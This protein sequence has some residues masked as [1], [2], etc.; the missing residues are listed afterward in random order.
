[1]RLRRLDLTRYGKFT[2]FA[3]DFGDRTGDGPD[4]HIVYG[5]NEAGKSTAFA[6]YL[7][8]LFGIEPQSRYDFLHGYDTMEIGATLEI[9][10]RHHALRRFKQRTASLRDAT[11][12]PVNEALLGGALSGLSREAYR[13]MFSLDDQTLEDGG[14]A[15]LESK[16][17]LGELLFAASAGLVSLSKTLAHIETQADA[18]FRKR[19]SSTEIAALKRRLSDLKDERERIDTQANAHAKL[20]AMLKQADDA[21]A[22][23]TQELAEFKVRKGGLEGLLRATPHAAEHARLGGD[24]DELGDLPRPPGHWQNRLPELMVADATL[25]E[26]L[27]SADDRVRKLQAEV[28]N[29]IVDDRLLRLGDRIQALL[30]LM[31]RFQGAEDDLPK[32]RNDLSTRESQLAHIARSLTGK[33]DDD[34]DALVVEASTLGTLRALLERWSGVETKHTTAAQERDGATIALEQAVEDRDALTRTH[35][36]LEAGLR[37]TLQAS[38]SRVREDGLLARHPRSAGA[39]ADKKREALDALRLLAPWPGSSDELADLIVP[40]VRQLQDWRDLFTRLL[41]RRDGY[42]DE[43]RSLAA[44]QALMETRIATAEVGVSA[45]TDDRADAAR[46]TREETWSSHL[47]RLDLDSASIFE[48]A[49]R[50]LDSLS[51]VRIEANDRL[52][53]I[54]SLRAE[55]SNIGVKSA[56]VGDALAETECELAAL[57]K[58]IGAA[59]PAGV[60]GGDDVLPSSM[61]STI[62]DWASKRATALKTL[63]DE[64]A[65]VEELAEIEAAIES[66]GVR[67]GKALAK[68]GIAVEGLYFGALLSAS[69]SLVS[70]EAAR[71]E[72]QAAAD[73]LVTEA[74]RRLK[75]RQKAEAEAADARET[76]RIAW[77]RALAGSWL[78]QFSEDLDAIRATLTALETLPALLSARDDI[79]HRV[80]AMED[81]RRIFRDAV[82]ALCRDAGE[83]EKLA[84]PPEEAAKILLSRHAAAVQAH[85]LRKEKAIEL[86]DSERRREHIFEEVRLHEVERHEMLALLS[87]SDLTEA[88]KRL[89]L[90]VRREQIEEKHGELSTQI[91]RDTGSVSLELALALLAE[92]APPERAQ[93]HAECMQRI[94][95]LEGRRQ[96]LFAER[97][98]AVDKVSAIGGDDAAARIEGDRRTVILEIED[99]AV[100]YLHLKTGNLLAERALQAYREQHRGSM[101]RRASEAFRNITRG[102][103]TGLTTIPEKERETLIALPKAGGSKNANSLSKGTRFQLYLALRVAGYEEFLLGQQPVPFISDDILETFDEP[104]SEVVLSVFEQMSRRGQVICFTH[105]RHICDLARKVVPTVQV[106]E[107]PVE[108]IIEKQVG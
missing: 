24:L 102:S 30:P 104:R 105:H 36:P 98:A 83:V 27:K 47:A 92:Q 90:C 56:M 38:V 86:S 82:E 1:M 13:V 32:R 60:N 35:P 96:T 11:G 71:F 108:Q 87:V 9:H 54:R 41:L 74:E 67:L 42:R 79:R 40:S 2:D 46:L 26:K 49:M 39:A 15:I 16:G 61:I 62:E 89:R 75:T 93:A 6:A 78:V 58:T 95:D 59:L 53:E 22:Q 57:A 66:E 68:A 88:E 3:L 77:A 18:I 19:A 31:S 103:Y 80:S 48:Q 14:K 44:Q 70:N 99:K 25:T 84:G 65:A 76:W 72:K 29:I 101:M 17:D 106:H 52:A 12:A 34:P 97:S 63:Q 69:D 55:L 37:A 10:G 21:Y 51:Q 100:R 5:L 107:L 45:I 28:D 43:R 33:G 73:K 23:T 20:I 64:R 50:A 8:L 85:A 7:D 94:D 4:F 91:M 81:D